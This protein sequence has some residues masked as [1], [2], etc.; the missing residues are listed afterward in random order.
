MAERI[1]GTGWKMNH[2]RAQARAYAE[3]LRT[4]EP[5]GGVQL[6]VL[7]PFTSLALVA[8]TL[9]GLIA[10]VCVGET[11]EE[12]GLGAAA[13]TV[14]R[15]VRMALAGLAASDAGRVWLAY[16]PVWAIGEGGTPATPQHV[17]RIH[18][19]IREVAQDALGAVPKVLYGGSVNADNARALAAD[20][21]VDGL[22]VGRAAWTADGLLQIARIAA[23]L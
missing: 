6:F 18:G 11:A 2:T 5:P 20:P 22:F 21:S 9:A 15:Q 23:E 19:R 7:P 16:E 3:T 4:T 17:R 10:L 12:H 14:E 8:E 13:A 1:V